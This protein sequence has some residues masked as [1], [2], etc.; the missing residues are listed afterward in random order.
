MK[1]LVT[2]PVL[3]L[4]LLGSD[5]LAAEPPAEV[6]PAPREVPGAVPARPAPVA[7]PEAYPMSGYYRTSRYAL[8]QD[9]APDLQG[10]Y[11]PLV[12]FA[13]GNG[14]Y[15]LYNGAPY[16]WAINYQ[17]W[18]R[19]TLAGT[20]YRSVPAYPPGFLP[21]VPPGG[22]PALAPAAATLPQPRTLFGRTS[23]WR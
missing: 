21:G 11:R 5:L 14:Y 17:D 8:W 18:V 10:Q 4:L 7:V 20:P 19:P 1:A 13:P 16:P 15:Y 23:F 12:G 22:D 2:R 3:L 9:Y 6:L